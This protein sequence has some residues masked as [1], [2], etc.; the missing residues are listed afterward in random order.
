MREISQ[1]DL[2]YVLWCIGTGAHTNFST[3]SMREDGGIKAIEAAIEKLSKT[4]A[5]HISQYGLGNDAR[6]TGLHEV[7]LHVQ[8]QIECWEQIVP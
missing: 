6:L 3:K 4:H 1:H 8:F 2:T 5:E 7:T